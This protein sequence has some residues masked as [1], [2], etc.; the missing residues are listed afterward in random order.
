MSLRK[1]VKDFENSLQGNLMVTLVMKM[2]P[3]LHKDLM[4]QEGG[5][6]PVFLRT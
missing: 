1:D 2:L 6:W 3:P 4:V 5:G